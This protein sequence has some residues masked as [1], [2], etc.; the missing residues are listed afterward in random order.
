MNR[1]ALFALFLLVLNT[2]YAIEALGMQTP[3]ARGEPG[4]AFIPL[5]LAALL[6]LAAGRILIGELR[7]ASAPAEDEEPLSIKPF[8]LAALTAGF[9]A[10][11][12]PAGYW[13]A[14]LAY[15][16]SVAVLFEWEKGMRPL[17]MLAMA[18]AIAVGVTVAGHLFFVQLFDL[19]LPEG[20][21]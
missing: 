3:F 4:P 6:Y 14:T 9:V 13:V 15:T 5:L 8:G 20:A 17:R 10:A 2:G 21:W 18:S 7:N 16:F 19:Y 11:F 12:E 1:Q